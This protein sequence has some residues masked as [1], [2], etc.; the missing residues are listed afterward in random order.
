[1]KLI[2]NDLQEDS[3]F[4]CKI[5]TN[6]YLLTQTLVCITILHTHTLKSNISLL[7]LL[8]FF[9]RKAQEH[10]K[11][12]FLLVFLCLKKITRRYCSLRICQALYKSVCWF[13]VFISY[14][15]MVVFVAVTKKVT[16]S[17]FLFLLMGF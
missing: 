14:D 11:R 17:S 6:E 8:A 15:K 5:Y 9:H 3:N 16:A 13:I 12:T 4:T 10:K 2:E 1:M 7:F